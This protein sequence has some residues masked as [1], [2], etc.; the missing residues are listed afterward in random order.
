MVLKSKRSEGRRNK[1]QYSQ[2]EAN[3]LLLVMKEL[4]KNSMIKKRQHFNSTFYLPRR[5][6]NLVDFNKIAKP[7]S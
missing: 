3:E 6:R 4:L 1:R 2:V 7:V 5:S